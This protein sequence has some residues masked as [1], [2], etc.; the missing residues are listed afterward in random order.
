MYGTYMI[1]LREYFLILRYPFFCL[2]PNIHEIAPE[3]KLLLWLGYYWNISLFIYLLC[4][5]IVVWVPRWFICGSYIGY[6]GA[7][8]PW[9]EIKL[10]SC[11]SSH[12][13]KISTWFIVLSYLE[14]FV[15]FGINITQNFNLYP[16]CLVCLLQKISQIC[17]FVFL[18]LMNSM[19]SIV[20]GYIDTKF[21]FGTS[22]FRTLNNGIVYLKKYIFLAKYL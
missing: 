4:K 11:L 16:N 10:F 8:F 13:C 12:V 21:S 2:F 22:L 1:L 18:H 14:D 19:R 17:L 15:S 9:V 7:E 5:E 20:Y 3:I 6:N